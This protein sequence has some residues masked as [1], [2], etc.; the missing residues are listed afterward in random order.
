VAEIRLYIEGGGPSEHT[1]RPLRD[2]FREFF[3]QIHQEARSKK[4][5]FTTIVC[6]SREQ[7]LELFSQALQD[8]PDAIN[9]LLIDADEPVVSGPLEHV[10]RH[11]KKGWPGLAEERCH[12]MVQIMEAWFLADV[13]RLQEYYSKG[14]RAN[15]IPRADDVETVPIARV[16][17]ALKDATHDCSK[18]EYHKIHHASELL[19]RVRT[20]RVRSASKHCDRLFKTLELQVQDS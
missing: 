7:T 14:F 11:F 18:G 2:G 16:L 9:L 6:G 5:K 4:K 17:R 8:H 19:Q 13:E 3:R 1:K 10:K 12:L 15:S 20:S